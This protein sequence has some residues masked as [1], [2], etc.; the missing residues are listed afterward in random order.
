MTFRPIRGWRGSTY[1]ASMPDHRTDPIGRTEA[2]DA[3]TGPR[4]RRR[5]PWVVLTLAL[6]PLLVW[7]GRTAWTDHQEAQHQGALDAFYAE[8]PGFAAAAPG[9]ILR[10]EPMDLPVK[11]AASVTRIL[12]RTET[13]A[14]K[15]AF[16]SG[17]VFLPSSPAPAG[18]RK[19]VAWAHGTLGFGDSCTPS[20]S[21]LKPLGD[22]DGWL[23]AML[24]NGWIVTATDYAGIGTPGDPEYLIGESEA[25]DVVNSVRAAASLKDAQ[26]S[27]KYAV[28]GHSQGGHS[29]LFTAMLSAS[30]APDLTLVAASAAAPAAELPALFAAQYQTPVAWVIG[31]DATASW[32]KVYPDLP[33]DVLT[34]KATKDYL[35]LAR[36]CVLNQV[37]TLAT[38]KVFKE[39]FFATN[40][41]Q[42][43]AWYAA[44]QAQTVR[45]ADIPV[46]VFL[47]QGTAD[48]VVLP[49]TTALLHQHLCA[50]GVPV[51]TSWLEGVDHLH[52]AIDSGLD[53]TQWLK[54]R[55]AGTPASNT[56][57]EK[58]PV[59]PAVAPPAP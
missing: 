45:A 48:T 23:E 30:I 41:L 16:S 57:D 59:A 47:S 35:E 13:F 15:P 12:Y 39:Q 51:T 26:A 5:W 37:G 58:P 7:G 21:R 55:F 42:N 4:R 52:V 46:P 31:P 22:T 3:T 53:L 34:P 24:A 54:E 2:A 17:M 25:R 19:V 27:T 6:V 44:A 9:D 20:R 56:C 14:G 8:P 28:W 32:P 43:K 10:Q 11:G 29:A 49:A 50:A 1:C 40:P 33:L 18:G 38:A 36:G